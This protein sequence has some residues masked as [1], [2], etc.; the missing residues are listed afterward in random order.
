VTLD[1]V[2][3]PVSI[4]K[5]KDLTFGQKII[6]G[7]VTSLSKGLKLSNAATGEIL[8]VSEGHVSRMINDLESKGYVRIENRQSKYRAIYL[9]IE[10]K[11]EAVLLQHRAQT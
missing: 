9:G 7:L 8:S 6:L 5:I 3:L 2:R 10:R 1:Y 4:L 11:V